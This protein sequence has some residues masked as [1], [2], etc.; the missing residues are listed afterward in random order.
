MRP[1]ADRG[2]TEEMAD[3]IGA[4]THERQNFP[5]S[6]P[7]VERNFFALGGFCAVK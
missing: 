3:R 7:T 2:G 1:L 4:R 5:K 6:R